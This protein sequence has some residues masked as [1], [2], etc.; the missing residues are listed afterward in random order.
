MGKNDRGF[1]KELDSKFK[2]EPVMG[3]NRPYWALKASILSSSDQKSNNLSVRVGVTLF[4]IGLG[5]E[6]SEI[7]KTGKNSDWVR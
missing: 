5:T 6:R 2:M 3:R 7:L 1:Y 4:F